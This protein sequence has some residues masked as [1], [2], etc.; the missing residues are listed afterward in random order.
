MCVS[1]CHGR[2]AAQ[3]AAPTSKLQGLSLDATNLRKAN[4]ARDEFPGLDSPMR[5]GHNDL[6]DEDSQYYPP[7]ASDFLREAS[8]ALEGTESPYMVCAL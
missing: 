1:G 5:D 8:Q 3:P 4:A 2:S 7:A 6:S